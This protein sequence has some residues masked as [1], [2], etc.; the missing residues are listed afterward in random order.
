MTIQVFTDGASRGNPGH[1]AAGI[2]ICN[3]DSLILYQLALYL[4]KKTNNE[5]EYLALRLALRLLLDK[6]NDQK[7]RSVC[8]YLDSKLVVEQMNK[9]WKIKEKRLLNL[10]TQCFNL[11][12][13]LPYP[14][15]FKHIPREKNKEADALANLAIDYSQ[16]LDS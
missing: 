11:I 1:A 13:D 4:G 8:F 16:D 9:K 14:V 10:A 12:Q 7:I 5:A 15:S 3:Q 2:Y 6:F